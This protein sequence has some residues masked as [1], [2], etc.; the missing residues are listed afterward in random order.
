[1]REAEELPCRWE[2]VGA[3]ID[4][5]FLEGGEQHSSG[6]FSVISG[7]SHYRGATVEARFLR[8]RNGMLPV[9]VMHQ[10]KYNASIPGNCPYF[11]K[12][13]RYASLD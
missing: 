3:A 13:I 4:F 2:G 8:C 10:R 7:P 12:D 5:R 1:M 6:V 11:E 9:F